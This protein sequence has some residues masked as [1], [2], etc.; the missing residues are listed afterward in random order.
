MIRRW[1]LLAGM[2]SVMSIAALGQQEL[3]TLEKGV[4]A[5]KLYQFH[6]IDTVNIFNG[7]VVIALPIGL[8]YPLNGGAS[9]QIVLS[10]NSNVWDL[11]PGPNG[12]TH[13]FPTIRSNA[14]LGWIVG[15]GRF[16]AHY[17][18]GNSG[19]WDIYESPDGGDH[20]YFTNNGA[21]SD[22]TALRLRYTETNSNNQPTRVE[23]DS[24]DG[25]VRHFDRNSDG[26]WDL[27][28]IRF[29]GTSDTVTFAK[30]SPPPQCPVPGYAWTIT[31]GRSRIHYLCFADRAYNGIQR[32]MIERIVLAAPH[33]GTAVYRFEYDE[34]DGIDRTWQDNDPNSGEHPRQIDKTALLSRVILPDQSSFDMTYGQ[35]GLLNRL[36]LPTKGAIDYQYGDRR[37]PANDF[38]AHN[39]GGVGYGFGLGSD[40]IALTTRKFTPAVTSGTPSPEMWV[41]NEDLLPSGNPQQYTSVYNCALPDPNGDIHPQLYDEMVVTVTDPTGGYVQNHFSVWP[42]EDLGRVPDWNISPAGFKRSNYGLP[43][44]RYDATQDRYL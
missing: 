9:Y 42:G 11:E 12:T 33:G 30:T 4:Q 5:D 21:T 43:Y 35:Y 13:G 14:G 20:R 37:I 36:T 16:F 1:L 18:T 7:D 22:G 24:P 26:T 23:V 6:D 19:G 31:D 34:R 10:Y 25:A 17:D 41:Y 29:A 39:Y 44:G 15:L 27:K 8:S 40:V 32:P 2:A 38:C 3:P 28:F